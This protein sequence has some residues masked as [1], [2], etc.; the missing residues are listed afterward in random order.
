MKPCTPKCACLNS[1][2]WTKIHSHPPWDSARTKDL[3]VPTSLGTPETPVVL[4][5]HHSL[6]KG[7][8]HFFNSFFTSFTHQRFDPSLLS[9]TSSGVLCAFQYHLPCRTCRAKCRLTNQCHTIFAKKENKFQDLLFHRP[10]HRLDRALP[11]SWLFAVPAISNNS[12]LHPIIPSKLPPSNRA[13]PCVQ[14]LPR[15]PAPTLRI[16]KTLQEL[17]QLLRRS[18][19][20]HSI[21]ISPSPNP[22][23]NHAQSQNTDS[24]LLASSQLF[25]PEDSLL[26]QRVPSRAVCLEV[27]VSCACIRLAALLQI[28]HCCFLLLP[29]P[30]SRC[31]DD[32]FWSCVCLH[33]RDTQY[34]GKCAQTQSP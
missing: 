8:L 3:H 26:D 9:L 2:S 12:Y 11:S 20:A 34:A 29:I 32:D 17:L 7:S 1:V 23:K 31:R 10:P 27:L 16:R 6:Y 33:E 18:S 14:F 28:L 4:E 24:P 13:S 19:S 30:L 25:C 22:C 21:D 5:A 15:F